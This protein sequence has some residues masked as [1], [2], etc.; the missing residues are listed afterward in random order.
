VLLAGYQAY[1]HAFV[2]KYSPTGSLIWSQTFYGGVSLVNSVT[3][4][5]QNNV[6]ITGE[7]LTGPGVTLQKFTPSGNSIWSTQI[8]QTEN[9]VGTVFVDNSQNIY[10]Y[11]STLAKYDSTGHLLW[12]R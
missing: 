2:N 6:Y 9:D 3:A 4:D 7:S 11:G 10:V 8:S 1:N 5:S 12:Q